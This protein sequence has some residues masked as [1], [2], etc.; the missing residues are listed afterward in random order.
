MLLFGPNSRVM[1][2]DMVMVTREVCDE[3]ESLHHERFAVDG[4]GSCLYIS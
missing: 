3:T 4:N 1:F 2:I